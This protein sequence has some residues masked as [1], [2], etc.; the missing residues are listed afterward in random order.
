MTG[1]RVKLSRV[2]VKLKMGVWKH[3][4]STVYLKSRAFHKRHEMIASWQDSLHPGDA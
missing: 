1:P 2:S 4:C 3:T